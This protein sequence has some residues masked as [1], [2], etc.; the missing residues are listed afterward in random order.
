MAI[1]SCQTPIAVAAE[2]GGWTPVD[3]G[4]DFVPAYPDTHA[5]YWV[6]SFARTRMLIKCSARR[7]TT[8]RIIHV[9]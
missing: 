2:C 6:W 5:Q 3:R 1:L 7:T 4:R 9:W 8:A